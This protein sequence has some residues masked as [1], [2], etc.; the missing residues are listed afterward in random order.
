MGVQEEKMQGKHVPFYKKNTMHRK[1]SNRKV[2]RTLKD[3]KD[4]PC[5]FISFFL[6]IYFKN[7]ERAMLLSESISNCLDFFNELREGETK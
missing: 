4:W 5:L 1:I 7:S 6:L 2:T 3:F